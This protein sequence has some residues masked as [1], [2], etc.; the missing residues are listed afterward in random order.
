MKSCPVDNV[1][2]KGQVMRFR[3]FEE[4]RSNLDENRPKRIAMADTKMLILFENLV[5]CL[6]ADLQRPKFFPR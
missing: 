5:K 1:F 4:N 6:V 3:K 2:K